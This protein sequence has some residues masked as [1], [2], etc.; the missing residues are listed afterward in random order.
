MVFRK[1]NEIKDFQNKLEEEQSLVASLQ[2]KIKELQVLFMLVPCVLFKTRYALWQLF[3][4]NVSD[5]FTYDR[6]KQ[7]NID[8]IQ[9]CMMN[10]CTFNDK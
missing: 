10:E 3:Y 1:D 5:L 9:I 2:K 8:I 7:I 4:N 6:Y